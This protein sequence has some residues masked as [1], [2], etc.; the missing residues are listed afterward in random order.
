LEKLKFG[1]AVFT[2]D[3]FSYFKKTVD[4]LFKFNPILKKYPF[5]IADDCSNKRNID[6]MKEAWPDAH[7]LLHNE[8]KGY[9]LNLKQMFLCAESLDLD[10]LYYTS[11]DMECVREIDFPA[12]IKFYDDKNVGQIQFLHWKGQIGDPIRERGDFNWTTREPIKKEKPVKV[13]KEVLVPANWSFTWMSQMTRLKTGI[14]IWDGATGFS[15]NEKGAIKGELVAVAN[16]ERMGLQNYEC[17]NQ[18]VFNQDWDAKNRT[19]KLR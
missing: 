1:V 9:M 13:G 2:C 15:K 14:N 7:L 11:N 16:A 6:E 10:V 18:P 5:I 17:Q 8:R 19:K 12:L 3:R 4:S